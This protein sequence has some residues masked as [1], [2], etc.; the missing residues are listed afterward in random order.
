[1]GADK[2]Y[3]L[4]RE[5]GLYPK[6]TTKDSHMSLPRSRS[7]NGPTNPRNKPQ[8]ILKQKHDSR[9]K[10]LSCPA[11]HLADCPQPPGGPFARARRTVRELRRTVRKMTTN[12]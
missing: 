9:S 11:G 10:G 5:L 6:F 12:L 3:S 1:M 2:N 7:H 8:A 4:R